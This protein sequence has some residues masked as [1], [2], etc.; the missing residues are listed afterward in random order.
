MHITASQDKV[1]GL[2]FNEQGKKPYNREKSWIIAEAGG[3][4]MSEDG[5]EWFIGDFT[6]TARE[7]SASMSSSSESGITNML[8]LTIRK[9]HSKYI[10]V[11]GESHR[12]TGGFLFI[13]TAE[14]PEDAAATT[15]YI[16][17]I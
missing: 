16:V 12:E 6:S 17:L 8:R 7:F 3:P 15:V 13:I 10:G 5:R 11:Y 4:Q 14:Y 2:T 1:I 9:S